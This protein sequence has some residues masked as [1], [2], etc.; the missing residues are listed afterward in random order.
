MGQIMF[1]RDQTTG[2]CQRSCSVLPVV[3]TGDEGYATAE[4][5][6]IPLG[7]SG[8]GNLFVLLC[9]YIGRSNQLNSA[10]TAQFLLFSWQQR[11]TGT[12]RPSDRKFMAILRDCSRFHVLHTGMPGKFC[13]NVDGNPLWAR[14][15]SLETRQKENARDRV[16]STPQVLEAMKEM[17]R[18]KRNP[19]HWTVQA[20]ESYLFFV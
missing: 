18:Q 13:C 1:V 2:K 20:L 6:S 10:L 12:N 9:N 14:S 15:C 11:K 17:R 5:E 8:T 19:Y 16:L 3:V 7:C 4:A